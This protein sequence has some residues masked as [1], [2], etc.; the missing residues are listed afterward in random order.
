MDDLLDLKLIDLSNIAPEWLYKFLPEGR[1]IQAQ[2]NE[3]FRCDH[4]PFSGNGIA[5]MSHEGEYA[6]HETSLVG[7]QQRILTQR[8]YRDFVRGKR[9]RQADQ[10]ARDQMERYRR[11]LPPAPSLESVVNDHRLP[12][13][14]RL[15]P[16]AAFDHH[17]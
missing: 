9:A 8:D 15:P 13:I 2:Q 6:G 5:A 17:A 4:C 3:A 11:P 10:L 7:Q 1:L 12:S 14:A 16:I